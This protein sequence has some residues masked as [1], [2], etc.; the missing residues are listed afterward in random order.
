MKIKMLLILM[1]YFNFKEI[2]IQ[3]DIDFDINGYGRIR[4]VITNLD[5]V[6]VSPQIYIESNFNIR[7]DLFALV[8]FDKNVI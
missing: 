1:I 8:S 4:S 2:S 3:A 5:G 7:D 6:L